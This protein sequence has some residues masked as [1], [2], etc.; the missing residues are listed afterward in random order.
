MIKTKIHSETEEVQWCVTHEV[1][2]YG[3]SS[4]VKHEKQW[5]LR[6]LMVWCER[7]MLYSWYLV[8]LTSNLLMCLILSINLYLIDQV[9]LLAGSEL[10]SKRFFHITFILFA[11]VKSTF[12]HWIWSVVNG[13]ECAIQWIYDASVF[14]MVQLM[15]FFLVFGMGTTFT[16]TSTIIGGFLLLLL[17]NID[18]SSFDFWMDDTKGRELICC[19]SAAAVSISLG[20]WPSANEGVLVFAGCCIEESYSFLPGLCPTKPTNNQELS[21]G[22]YEGISIDFVFELFNGCGSFVL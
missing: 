7:V 9:S 21:N 17:F 3:C 15:V 14:G 2:M 10:W 6:M 8:K 13:A 5:K 22:Q 11:F 20:R 4:N 18:G 12:S 1:M 16:H 19:C